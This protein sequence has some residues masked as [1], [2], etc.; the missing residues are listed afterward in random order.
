MVEFIRR[1]A[2]PDLRDNSGATALMWAAAAGSTT[3]LKVLME[4]R[5]NP[6]LLDK[7]GL[8]ARDY[9]L[10]SGHPQIAQLLTVASQ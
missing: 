5:A 4:N 9:A 3:C 1:G 8:N 2:N 6:L 10:R 7:W